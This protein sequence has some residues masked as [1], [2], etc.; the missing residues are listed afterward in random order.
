MSD[1]HGLCQ[2]NAF[3]KAIETNK[4]GHA[5]K[6]NFDDYVERLRKKHG[7]GTRHDFLVKGSIW[8][9]PQDFMMSLV[10]DERYLMYSWES[11]YGF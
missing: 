6:I 3:G 2:I 9:R 4:N 7:K 10:K 11:K 8:D 5:L 1:T